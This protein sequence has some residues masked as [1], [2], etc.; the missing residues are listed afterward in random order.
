M[1]ANHERYLLDEVER[2]LRSD[3]PAFVDRLGD[4]LLV[5]GVAAPAGLVATLAAA[6]GWSSTVRIETEEGGR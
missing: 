5:S 2:R 6:V 1:L 3:D 4:G